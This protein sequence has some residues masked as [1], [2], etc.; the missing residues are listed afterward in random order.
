MFVRSISSSDDGDDDD[1]W[2]YTAFGAPLRNKS[3]N[4]TL[5]V[6]ESTSAKGT[7]LLLGKERR[8]ISC[9]E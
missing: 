5:V 2:L 6:E 4:N 3:T 1:N 9:L 8:S 7:V